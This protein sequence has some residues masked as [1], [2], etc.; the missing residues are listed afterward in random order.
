MEGQGKYE[1]NKDTT[2]RK[3]ERF[4]ETGPP[5]DT[6]IKGSRLDEGQCQEG[7]HLSRLILFIVN[8]CLNF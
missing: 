3:K 8:F 6:Q 4:V 7:K 5:T 1:E 2:K